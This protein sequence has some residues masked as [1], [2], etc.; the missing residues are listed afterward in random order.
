M[1]VCFCV[2]LG[3][4]TK[5]RCRAHI[6][7]LLPLNSPL[8]TVH[9]YTKSVNSIVCEEQKINMKHHLWP[10]R[11]TMVCFRAHNFLLICQWNVFT[12]CIPANVY[13]LASL[14]VCVCLCMYLSVFKLHKYNARN[15]YP[16]F[17]SL[18]FLLSFNASQSIPGN[19]DSVLS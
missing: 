15:V 12:K 2:A 18:F 13:A 11:L 9:A 4:K 8:Y 6:Q 5:L 14:C 1:G 7:M 19:S 16:F 17:Y 3:E 10:I